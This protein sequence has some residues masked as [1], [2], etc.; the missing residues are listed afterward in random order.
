MAL[1]KIIKEKVWREKVNKAIHIS[2]GRDTGAG[3]R[4]IT[5]LRRELGDYHESARL[6]LPGCPAEAAAV[7]ASSCRWGQA[8]CRELSL[9]EPCSFLPWALTEASLWC[10][11]LKFQDFC[12][13]NHIHNYTH[14]VVSTG[15]TLDVAHLQEWPTAW[16]AGPSANRKCG[17][18]GSEILRAAAAVR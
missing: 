11:N 15:V 6:L 18:P 17:N 9:L 4:K 14:R 5:V 10:S 2:S 3:Q 7:R 8:W 12:L 13:P 16:C 1:I